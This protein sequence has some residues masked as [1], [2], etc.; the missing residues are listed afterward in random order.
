[1]IN[2][3]KKKGFGDY[4]NKTTIRITKKSIKTQC[5]ATST[6]TIVKEVHDKFH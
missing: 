5:I 4:N 1:M 6:R 2:K 3:P